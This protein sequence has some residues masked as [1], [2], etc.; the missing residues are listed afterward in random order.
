MILSREDLRNSLRRH[1]IAPVYVLFGA[2]TYL[3]DLALRTICDRSFTESDLRD[4]NETEYS[5]NIEGN[6]R[7]ALAAADQLPM[8]AGRRVIR[9]VD[10]RVSST[11]AKDTLRESDEAALMAYLERPSE[12]SVVI[13]VADEVDKRR[14]IAKLLTDHAVAAE[15]VELSD[16]ELAKFAR[17]E[18]KKNG[19]EIDDRGLRQLIALVGPDLRRLTSEIEK[20][21]AA[22]LPG[23]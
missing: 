16:A 2:E 10:V 19:S 15:F 7:S 13:F 12:S 8:M 11:G 14:K 18:L 22:A 23:T 1:E 21:S 4:F 5:L 9:V 20:L 17:D 6:L 3:R